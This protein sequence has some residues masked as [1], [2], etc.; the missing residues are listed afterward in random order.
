MST[1]SEDSTDLGIDVTET[2]AEAA[3]SLLDA[4]GYDPSEAGLRLLAQ[5][6]GCDCGD[7]AYGI[8]LEDAV[9]EGDVSV[10]FHGLQV[11]V[12]DGS[13]EHVGDLRLDYIDDFRGE[14]FTLESTEPK[15]GGCG[16]GGGHHH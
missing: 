15:E 7:I 10:E 4:E 1:T 13:Q 5:E 16:C 3:R 2:A 6:K 14:G 11:I 9:A 12:D 8:E